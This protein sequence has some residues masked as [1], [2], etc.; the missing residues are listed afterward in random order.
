MEFSW[1]ILV[2]MEY[3]SKNY[4]ASNILLHFTLI[5]LYFLFLKFLLNEF[6][7]DSNSINWKR[8]PP[9]RVIVNIKYELTK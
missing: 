3:F 1:N 9:V 2:V 5:L 7:Y 4:R 6:Y 8:D